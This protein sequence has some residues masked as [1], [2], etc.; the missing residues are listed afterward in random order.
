[1]K[2]KLTIIIGLILI[3]SCVGIFWYLS[4]NAGQAD[5]KY[6][7]D[8]VRRGNFEVKVTASGSIQ[9][10]PVYYVNP[11]INA[12][13]IEV[14][15]KL[16]DKVTKGQLLAVLDNTDLNNAYKSA[17]Y[18]FNAA[19]YARD[20]L[21]NAPVVDDYAVKR[22]QQQVNVAW[23]Q[24]QSAKNNLDLANIYAPAD[25]EILTWNIKIDDFVSMTATS[26][27]PLIAIGN[28]AS[29]VSVLNINELDINKIKTGQICEQTID[30]AGGLHKGT[31]KEIENNGTS[32]AGIIYYKV[33][34]VIEDMTGLKNN[35][36]V[37]AEIITLSKPDVVY[38]PT[39]TIIQRNG[40]YFLYIADEYNGQI[41][42]QE[43]KITIGISNDNDTEV[44]SGVSEGQEIIINYN[45]K[46]G[47]L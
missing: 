45:T 40:E 22:A 1:M 28:T 27:T 21:K 44:L 5:E 18:N 8:N 10:D 33:K 4:S 13:V 25:G 12:K 17:Q 39:G 29:Y 26:L 46:T 30:A 7:T 24:V 32:A 2:K 42:P 35:M 6:V 31:V 16:G 15:A 9:A 43:V 3:L 36:S 19:V 11:R 34:C 38:V 14:K 23:V 37:D 41:K 20:Q 47:T